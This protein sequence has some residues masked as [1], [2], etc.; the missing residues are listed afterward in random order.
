LIILILA[1]ELLMVSEAAL[2]SLLTV[3]LPAAEKVAS[4]LGVQA[5][6]L[7]PFHQALPPVQLPLPPAV[8]VPVELQ[9]TLAAWMCG[10]ASRVNARAAARARVE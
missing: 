4:S 6:A 1:E 3:V 8:E 9:V 10:A 7:E 5:T 2:T